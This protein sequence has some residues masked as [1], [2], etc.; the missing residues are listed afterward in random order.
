MLYRYLLSS[1]SAPKCPTSSW[2]PPLNWS[3]QSS[4]SMIETGRY[5]SPALLWTSLYMYVNKHL[6]WFQ[7][8]K[9]T[10]EQVWSVLDMVGVVKDLEKRKCA[11]LTAEWVKQY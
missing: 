5:V 2:L 9:T 3:K 8:G 6:F 4:A 11:K 7:G 1:D 10:E